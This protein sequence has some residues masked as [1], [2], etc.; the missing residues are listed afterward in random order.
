MTRVEFHPEAGRDLA[1]AQAWY[2]ERSEVAAQAFALEINNALATIQDAPER[3]PLTTRGARRFLLSEFP[4]SNL[5][6]VRRTDV[7][8]TA[9][10]HQRRRLGYWQK[11]A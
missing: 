6:Y 11:R 7:Y 4:Y 10:A 1:E 9:V 8:V 5:Y 2:R 3:W